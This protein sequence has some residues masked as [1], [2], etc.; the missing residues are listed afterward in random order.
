MNKRVRLGNEGS[1]PGPA[2]TKKFTSGRW[3]NVR[4]FIH[5]LVFTFK[6]VTPLNLDRLFDEC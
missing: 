1:F 4:K 3:S 2:C 6:D 5:M